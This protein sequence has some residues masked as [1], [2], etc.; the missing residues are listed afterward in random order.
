MDLLMLLLGFMS[1]MIGVLLPSLSNKK[2][3][4]NWQRHLILL[5]ALFGF[6]LISSACG[7]GTEQTSKADTATTETTSQS[8]DEKEEAAEQK[9][10]EEK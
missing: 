8:S 4:K 9:K 3:K 10:A 7:S 2:S 5:S 1:L 6:V